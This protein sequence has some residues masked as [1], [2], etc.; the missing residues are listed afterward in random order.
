MS[1]SAAQV[2]AV[3]E[4]QSQTA[5]TRRPTVAALESLLHEP[6]SVLDH[7]FVRVV[8]YM[9]DDA[10]IVQAARVSYGRGTTRLS[11]DRGLIRYLVRHRHTTPLEMCE[12]KAARQA[13]DFHRQ[14]VDSAPHRQRQRILGALFDPRREFYLPHPDQLA[15]QSRSNRQGANN[16]CR[17]NSR[18]ACCGTF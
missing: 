5:A 11:N 8:D 6:F 14:T 10:A 13:A 4:A 17:K 18:R 12:I 16:F 2:E 7:G 3:R 15:E 1:L 9:G